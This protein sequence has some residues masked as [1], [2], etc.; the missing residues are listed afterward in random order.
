MIWNYGKFQDEKGNVI[1]EEPGPDESF[2]IKCGSWPNEH[3]DCLKRICNACGEW[4]GISPKG[5]AYHEV[6]PN[7][8]PLFCEG[9]FDLLV[10]ML[11]E[12][13]P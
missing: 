2:P 1:D 8:R 6:N 7:V 13:N 4:V 5:W 9:C 12:M 10:I 11:Q 3:P